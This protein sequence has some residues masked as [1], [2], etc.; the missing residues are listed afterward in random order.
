[1][2]RSNRWS[3][4]AVALF[5]MSMGIPVVAHADTFA[6]IQDNLSIDCGGP[7]GCGTVTVTGLG[8][9]YINSGS[10]AIGAVLGDNAA[11]TAAAI[12]FAGQDNTFGTNTVGA[13]GAAMSMG[14]PIAAH[15]DTFV[16]IQDNLSINCGGPAGCGTV[17]VTGLGTTYINSGSFAIGAVLG[18]NSALNA[19]AIT[20][21]GQ[22]NTFGTNTVGAS[23]VTEPISSNWNFVGLDIAT[24][25]ATGFAASSALA[26][27]GP[28]VG[29]GLPGF[30]AACGGLLALARRRRR[31]RSGPDVWK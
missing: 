10:F 2:E 8:T 25:G 12:T 20:F 24:T 4:T 6:I 18:D 21:A 5:A 22:D 31:R 1:M 29:A 15:A 14:I 19:A 9:T 28:V 3:V 27:P 16:I 26:V 7:A 30:V 13:S 11:L 23:G 17:T